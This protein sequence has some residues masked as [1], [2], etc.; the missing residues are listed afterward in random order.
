MFSFDFYQRITK[1]F[2]SFGSDV[3]ILVNFLFQP[4]EDAKA[5]GF[6]K[7]YDHCISN[8]RYCAKPEDNS[9]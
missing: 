8:G 3:K 4:N 1:S 7:P 2:K 9:S 6:T 5:L